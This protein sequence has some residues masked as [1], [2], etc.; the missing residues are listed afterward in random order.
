MFETFEIINLTTNLPSLLHETSKILEIDLEYALSYFNNEQNPKDPSDIINTK[1]IQYESFVTRLGNFILELIH[2]QE[3][4]NQNF[5]DFLNDVKNGTI[6]PEFLENQEKKPKKHKENIEPEIFLLKTKFGSSNSDENDTLTENFPENQKKISKNKA[7]KAKKIKN[8]SENPK[9]SI[10][11]YKKWSL[12]LLEAY[13]SDINTIISKFDKGFGVKFSHLSKI[14]DQVASTLELSINDYHKSIFTDLM[15]LTYPLKKTTKKNFLKKFEFLELFKSWGEKYNEDREKISGKLSITIKEFE[16]LRHFSDENPKISLILASLIESLKFSL[17]SFLETH[18]EKHLF[19]KTVKKNLFEIFLFYG[20]AQKIQGV[21]DTFEGLESSN[22]TWNLAK[23]LKFC[24]DFSIL[25][26]KPESE[27]GLTKENLTLIFKKTAANTRLMNENQ[28]LES[29]EII[30]DVFYSPAFDTLLRTNFAELSKNQKKENF[31]EFLKITKPN[32]YHLKVKAFG[33]PH[34]PKDLKRQPVFE[35]AKKGEYILPDSLKQQIEKWNFKQTNNATP[36]N[37]GQSIYKKTVKNTRI[38]K[39]TNN[40]PLPISGYASRMQKLKK[41]LKSDKETTILSNLENYSI[42]QIVSPKAGDFLSKIETPRGEN[43]KKFKNS[44]T[45][46]TMQGL[47][48]LNY[49]DLDDVLNMKDLISD[50]PDEYFDNLY[51]V[52]PKLEKIMKMHEQ[53]IAKGQKVV[54]K[55]F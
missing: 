54:S 11:P 12:S 14:F 45:V 21:F 5:Q 47:N 52:E 39:S 40:L 6:K 51:K 15:S 37:E 35:F 19:R 48:S 33:P 53:K 23:F 1:N 43:D 26:Q 28:F 30:S 55:M 42:S 36:S 31:Y 17:T 22:T 46:I 34:T 25:T 24:T 44:T 3:F 27:R 50:D 4:Y 8:S 38:R 32:S 18:K 7:L 29:L 2:K 49:D 20:K 13:E 16:E 9:Q 41:N 10:D